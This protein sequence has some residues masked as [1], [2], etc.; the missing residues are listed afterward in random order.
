[1]ENKREGKII[2]KFATTAPK[3]CGIEYKKMNMKQRTLSLYKKK[4]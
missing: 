3:T 1:M 4:E 2:T